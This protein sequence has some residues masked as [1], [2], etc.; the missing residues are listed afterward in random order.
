MGFGAGMAD[1]GLEVEDGNAG[2][3]GLRETGMGEKSYR[4]GI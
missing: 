1:T 3:A 4:E 2:S